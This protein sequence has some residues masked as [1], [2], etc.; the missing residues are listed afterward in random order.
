MRAQAPNTDTWRARMIWKIAKKDFLLNLMT[1]KFA[2]GM[3]VSVVLAAV[4][5]PVLTNDYQQ[6]LRV[7]NRNVADNEAE[8]RKVMVYKNITPTVY[9]P[10]N[11]LSVFA[12][13]VEKRLGNSALIYYERIPKIVAASQEGNPYIS[14]FPMFDVSLI[15]KIVLSILAMLV[16]YD[17]ISGEREQGT[18]KLTLS[19]EIARYQVLLGKVLA[20]LITLL[21]PLTTVFLVVLFMLQ[22]SPMVDFTGSDWARIGSM[23]IISLVFISVMYNVGLLFSC[24]TRKSAIS[25]I[26]GLFFW[27]VYMVVIPNGSTY[28]ATRILPLESDE[29]IQN[30]LLFVQENRSS[31]LEKIRKTLPRGAESDDDGAFGKWYPLVANKGAIERWKKRSVLEDP[32]KIKYAD[33]LWEVEH[34]YLNSLFKQKYLAK[35]IS[36][37]SP[38]SLYENAM[39]AMA[40]TDLAS[41]RYSMDRVRTYRNSVIDYIRSKTNNFSSLSYFTRSKKGDWEEYQRMGWKRWREKK[42]AETPPLDLQ[43][44][45]QFDYEPEF[46]RNLQTAIADI[47]LLLFMN[48]CFFTLSFV[49]FLRYDVRSE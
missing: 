7:Y 10:P 26:L 37:L 11:I 16:A 34:S 22:L 49:A 25:L 13:G 43:D 47:G 27:I 45:P 40:G 31:E 5:M 20:G 23:Y 44:L 41:S 32:V 9:R 19:A 36:R 46:I 2:A 8:L 1:F 28:L 3:I 48:V 21:I 14:N 33:R 18:L 4:F 17:V 35:N 15:L 12:E 39:S 24:L 6:R 38:I 30:Q 42:L 29:K